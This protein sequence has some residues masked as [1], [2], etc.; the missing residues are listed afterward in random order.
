MIER[1]ISM[2]SFSLAGRS[3][4]RSGGSPNIID[5]LPD[6]ED[7]EV[8]P[9]LVV[10]TILSNNPLRLGVYRRSFLF[11]PVFNTPNLAGSVVI[12]LFQIEP[13]IR[14][15]IGNREIHQILH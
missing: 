3:G 12:H 10:E 6:L 9:H 7:E 14:I 15:E 13:L 11:L 8:K 1:I 5:P 2:I 4:W